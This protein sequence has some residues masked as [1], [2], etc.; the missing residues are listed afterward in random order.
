MRDPREKSWCQTG[1]TLVSP[2]MCWQEQLATGQGLPA[3]EETSAPSQL[4]MVTVLDG[5]S[6]VARAG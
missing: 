1:I 5:R 6:M 2:I 4:F 3:E